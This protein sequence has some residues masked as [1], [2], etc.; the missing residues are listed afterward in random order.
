[1]SNLTPIQ[2]EMNRAH[3]DDR[4]TCLPNCWRSHLGDPNPKR[5]CQYCGEYIDADDKSIIRHNDWHL[6]NPESIK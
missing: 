4:S 2:E 5:K 3:S 6:A 1:M